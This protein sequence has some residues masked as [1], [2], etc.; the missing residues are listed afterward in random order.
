MHPNSHSLSVCILY[1][2]RDYTELTLVG[3]SA[4][5]A[6][7]IAATCTLPLGHTNIHIRT[8]MLCAFHVK[9]NAYTNILDGLLIAK[10]F[11]SMFCLSL[12]FSYLFRCVKDSFTD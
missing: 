11:S 5:T 7:A 6:G 4:G 3:L 8:Y 12:S 9:W 10:L 1:V 2:L